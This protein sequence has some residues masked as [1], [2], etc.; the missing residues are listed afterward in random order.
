M[1][2]E[3]SIPELQDFKFFWQRIPPRTPYKWIFPELAC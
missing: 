2:G 3:R 1:E